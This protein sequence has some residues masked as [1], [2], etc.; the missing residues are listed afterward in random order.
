MYTIQ[1]SDMETT[2]KTALFLVL[3]IDSVP[4]LRITGKQGGTVCNVPDA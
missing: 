4:F 2:M 3:R 1:V